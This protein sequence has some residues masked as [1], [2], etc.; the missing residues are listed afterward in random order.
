MTKSV[1]YL[2]FFINL[3]PLVIKG[4]L[5]KGISCRWHRK[6]YLGKMLLYLYAS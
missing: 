5:D 1:V 6:L 2:E 3:I 4:L